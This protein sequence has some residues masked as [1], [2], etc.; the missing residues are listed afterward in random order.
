MNLFANKAIL[1]DRIVNKYKPEFKLQK[2][3]Y[4][5]RKKKEEGLTWN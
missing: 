1:Y 4:C 5:E 2:P 3:V